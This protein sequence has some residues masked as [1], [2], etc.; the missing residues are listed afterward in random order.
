MIIRPFLTVILPLLSSSLLPAQ[1]AISSYTIDGGGGT[2]SGGSFALTG[3]VGQPDA[4]DPLSAGAFVLDGG[5]WAALTVTAGPGYAEWAAANIPV[6]L[7]ASFNGDANGDGIP[8][9]LVYVFGESGV[10]A[11]GARM[12]T[13]PPEPVPFDVDLTLFYSTDLENWM[14]LSNGFTIENGILTDLSTDPT[15]FYR[16]EA[17]LLP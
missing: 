8:N 15:R 12:L 3:T 16:Y 14:E 2:L 9:G 13:A 10:K 7:D 6:G 11:F 17:I 5:Y 1:L 4:N